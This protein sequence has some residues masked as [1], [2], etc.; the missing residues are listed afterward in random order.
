[1]AAVD[2]VKRMSDV[3]PQLSA[4]SAQQVYPPARGRYRPRIRRRHDPHCRR[5]ARATDI[6]RNGRTRPGPVGGAPIDPEGQIAGVVSQRAS[7][8]D[9]KRRRT[10]WKGSSSSFGPRLGRSRCSPTLS[11]STQ[12]TTGSGIG[13]GWSAT[14]SRSP[15]HHYRRAQVRDPLGLSTTAISGWAGADHALTANIRVMPGGGLE[16]AVRRR[17]DQAPILRTRRAG[18]VVAQ[19]RT[20]QMSQG[21]RGPCA[22]SASPA[23][24]AVA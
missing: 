21:W 22:S 11:A 18:S 10:A 16:H 9:G 4:D 19:R 2:A 15:S 3:L 8:V 12:S 5:R 13:H 14:A 6:R 23:A 20:V 24:A 1:M 7:P 17:P